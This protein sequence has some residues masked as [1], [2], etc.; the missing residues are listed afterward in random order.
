MVICDCFSVQKSSDALK[1]K[2]GRKDSNTKE[3]FGRR[4]SAPRERPGRKE[5]VERAKAFKKDYFGDDEDDDEVRDS[6]LHLV[7]RKDGITS[8]EFV[9][10]VAQNSELASVSVNH[11][12]VHA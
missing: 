9:T 11:P 1:E 8:L 4:E 5:S 3:K 12:M 10:L 7:Y 2:L 6:I